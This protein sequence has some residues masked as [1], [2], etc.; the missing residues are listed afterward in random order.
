MSITLPAEAYLDTL[1]APIE[2]NRRSAFLAE[3]AAELE[4]A[5]A[6]GEGA[7][8]RAAARIQRA[9]FDPPHDARIGNAAS[10]RT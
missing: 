1:A 7:V 8:Y 4:A 6:I 3:V 10:R 2:P 9:L 5:G